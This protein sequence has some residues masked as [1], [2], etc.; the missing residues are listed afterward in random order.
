MWRR[1]CQSRIQRLRRPQCQ[2]IR[3][4]RCPRLSLPLPPPTHPKQNL[5]GCANPRLPPQTRQPGNPRKSNRN[6]TRRKTRR[7]SLRVRLRRRQRPCLRV[8]PRRNLH[9]PRP[10]RQHHTRTPSQPAAPHL[11]PRLSLRASP[12]RT[13][14]R[15]LCACVEWARW[16]SWWCSLL[17]CHDSPTRRPGYWRRQSRNL[18]Q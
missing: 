4:L 7:R 15:N 12:T 10:K 8:S 17:H 18:G 6:R 3:R 14:S 13:T 5:R 1:L 2:R 11:P 16:W 9:T